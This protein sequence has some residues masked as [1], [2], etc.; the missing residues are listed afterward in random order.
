MMGGYSSGPPGSMCQPVVDSDMDMYHSRG[1]GTHGD[2]EDGST[3]GNHSK[4]KGRG[5]YKCG[6]V[7]TDLPRNDKRKVIRANH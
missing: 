7:S 2:D 5:S 3:M 1:V 6:R 4:D